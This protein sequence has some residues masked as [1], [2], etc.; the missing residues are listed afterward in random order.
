MDK[1]TPFTHPHDSDALPILRE[2]IAELEATIQQNN[3]ALI[4]AVCLKKRAEKAEATIKRVEAVKPFTE[5]GKG[6]KW[7][8]IDL[9]KEALEQEDE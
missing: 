5:T 6:S 1:S 8:H 9:L 7:V 3:I 2:R 4:E